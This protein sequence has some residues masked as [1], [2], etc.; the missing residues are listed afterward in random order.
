VSVGV[1]GLIMYGLLIESDLHPTK[2]REEQ[3]NKRTKEQKNRRIKANKK[4]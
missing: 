2:K 1:G 4:N 3:K